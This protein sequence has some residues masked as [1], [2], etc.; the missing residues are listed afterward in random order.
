M[1]DEFGFD[2]FDRPCKELYA[3][4]LAFIVRERS[5]DKSTKCGC[6]ITD[7]EG[8]ILSTGY[9]NPVMG[10]IDKNMPRE[11]EET[12]RYVV[13]EHAERSAIYMAARNGT[14]LRGSIFYISGLPCGD[15]LRG[16][17]MTGASKLIYGPNT[18]RMT[19]ESYISKY[20]LILSGQSLIVQN[21]KYTKGLYKLLPG[22]EE[23]MNDR[24]FVE[25]SQLYKNK[26]FIKYGNKKCGLN[27]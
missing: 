16:V 13:Y 1:I 19:D 2:E 5:I 25:S 6:V 8:A 9:N 14:A 4:H 27:I 24:P 7:Q 18:A 22:L 12:D 23:E 15:C 20:H 3:M 17:I 21:F 10:A 26:G 11:K